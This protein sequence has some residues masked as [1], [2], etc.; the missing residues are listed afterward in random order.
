MKTE[1]GKKDED[2]EEIIEVKEIPGDT[3]SKQSVTNSPIS[4][5]SQGRD[6]F[7]IH[8]KSTENKQSG[9]KP[10]E[11]DEARIAKFFAQQYDASY[12]EGIHPDYFDSESLEMMD[13]RHQVELLELSKLHVLQK[14]K[15]IKKISGSNKAS[16]KDTTKRSRFRLKMKKTD[17]L[18]EVIEANE[19]RYLESDDS[20]FN[21][22]SEADAKFEFSLNTSHN[23]EMLDS[24]VLDLKEAKMLLESLTLKEISDEIKKPINKELS[25]NSADQSPTDIRRLQLALHFLYPDSELVPTGQFGLTTDRY[26]RQM[27]KENGFEEDGLVSPGG[28]NT[29][30]GRLL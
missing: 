15:L 24:K 9:S 27:Q 21:S 18:T 1:Y 8:S 25:I 26:L 17:N 19:E 5:N 3:L 12:L 2:L 20:S 13:L 14:G 29:I 10:P 28:W 7:N 22:M 23:P 16:A 4:P 30:S 11:Y 6:S